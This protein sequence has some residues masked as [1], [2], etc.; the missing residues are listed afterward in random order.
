MV[1]GLLLAAVSVVISYATP[2][3]ELA[4]LTPLLV[5]GLPVYDLTFVILMRLRAGRP[6]LRKSRDHFVFRLIRHGWTAPKAVGAMLGL[7]TAFCGAALTVAF[8]SHLIGAVAAVVVVLVT[9]AWGIQMA[10]VK[11]DA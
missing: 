4:L 7:C 11:M 2:G 1:L 6:I 9:V 10:D 5:L 3:R 8:G